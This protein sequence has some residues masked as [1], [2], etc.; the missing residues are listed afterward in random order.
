MYSI[1]QQIL[2]PLIRLIP[3]TCYLCND[4]HKSANALCASCNALFTPLEHAC[5]ICA[6]PLSASPFQICGHCIQ[7]KPYFDRAIAPIAFNTVLRTLL[8][9]FKYHNQLYLTTFFAN[10]ILQ[11]LPEDAL[12]TQCL[13]PVPIHMTR[14]RQRGFN[15][16][17]LLTKLLAKKLQKKYDLRHCKK[18]VSTEPQA[19]LNV[20]DR[21][22]NLNHSFKV[23]PLPYQHVTIIDDVITT[24]STVNELAKT[25]KK[26]GVTKVDVWCCARVG[27][28]NQS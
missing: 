20:Y 16:A 24:G 18:I 2:Q 6:L 9:A 19:E 22:K 1:T 8:H 10:L 25:L 26:S 3:H 15:Q 28:K 21:Q 7:K 17:V 23:H 11:H 14:M 5:A 27:L 13:I 12:D 4:Y